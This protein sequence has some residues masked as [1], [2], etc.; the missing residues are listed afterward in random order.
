MRKWSRILFLY[1]PG[2]L[3]ATILIY[4]VA[5]QPWF[6][7][8][9]ATDLEVFARIP[10]DLLVPDP[11]MESTRAITIDAT[12]GEI[13]PWLIQIGKKRGGFYSYD[14]LENLFGCEIRSVSE[15]HSEWQDLAR[16]D[17]VHLGPE[18]YPFYLVAEVEPERLLVLVAG[19]NF[20]DQATVSTWVFFLRPLQ[21]DQTR[22]IVR[23]RTK[24]EP[25]V[26]NFLL[27]RC[28]TEPA[29]FIMEQ[30]MLRG[31]RKRAEQYARER[32]IRQNSILVGR[33]R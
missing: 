27:W 6:S 10:G 19:M 17:T 33:V 32:E 18:G 24:Y 31:I 16:G 7:R 20:T 2:I 29:S 1:V 8:W 25:E 14:W 12:A 13:W 9:G 23:N 21:D 22:L 4:F 30:K 26:G 11:S 3:L 5:L 15:I 28:I